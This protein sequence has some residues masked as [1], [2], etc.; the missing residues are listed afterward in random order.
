MIDLPSTPDLKAHLEAL[1]AEELAS[2]AEQ[3]KAMG[4]IATFPWHEQQ[5]K[6][7]QSATNVVVALGGNQSGKTT[8][9]RG[10][11][12]RLVRREGP[13]YRRLRN[14][15]RP[16][17]IWVSPTTLEKFRS[18]W[19]KQLLTEVFEPLGPVG[20]RWDYVSAPIPKFTWV[21]EFT[22]WSKPN[23]LWG[24]SHDQGFLAFESD[25]VDLIVFDEEPADR[26]L[27]SSAIARLSTTNGIILFTFTPLLGLSWT[28][29]EFYAPVVTPQGED[30]EKYKLSDRHWKR[31]NALTL[32]QMGMADNPASVAG[33]GVARINEDPGMSEA[34]KNTRLYGAYGYT[35]GM[36][37]R[38]L[39][40]INPGD[41][42]YAIYFL[43]ALPP[44][45][46][47]RW[48]I[49][50]DPNKRHGALLI[51]VDSDGNNYVVAEHYLEDVPDRLHAA[52]YRFLASQ[53][54]LDMDKDIE[55]WADPG[56][57]GGQAI[58]NLAD[59]GIIAGSVPK[60][61]GSVKASIELVRRAVSID[62]GHPHPVTG[63]PGAP[64]LYFLRS[65]TSAWRMA[66]L[67]YRESRLLWEVRQYRQKDNAPPDTPVKQYDDLVDCL[68]YHFL[69]RLQNPDAPPDTTDQDEKAKLDSLSLRATLEV[70]QLTKDLTQSKRRKD[71]VLG[72]I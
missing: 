10:V 11:V 53:Y 71:P 36:I 60:G 67:P 46:Q 39:A 70:E 57:A 72:W 52:G 6:I 12:S 48:S 31:G 24:K 29:G 44:D 13:V 42:K 14:K 49:L 58:L 16:L 55:V 66:G 64:R 38:E 17:K 7:L 23:E 19:E 26:R 59:H 1:S 3:V 45:R 56:G 47:Y 65:L 62:K 61:Q 69:V 54:K 9:G 68:R 8:V 40:G 15:E 21:D 5:I 63:E 35:E 22:S 34:E 51:A 4:P 18:N 27:Y 37:W 50:A 2:L 28:F 33:G 43:D 41:D 25:V 20:K 32:V 30:K